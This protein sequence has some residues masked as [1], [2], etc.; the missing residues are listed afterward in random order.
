MTKK[1]NIFADMKR[2]I[3][4]KINQD[5]K[6]K[7]IKFDIK[8]NIEKYIEFALNAYYSKNEIIKNI[9]RILYY[10]ERKK[11]ANSIFSYDEEYIRIFSK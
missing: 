6:K 9:S 5:L 2:N 11:N 7:K 4:K 10:F 1:T 3:N 8:L